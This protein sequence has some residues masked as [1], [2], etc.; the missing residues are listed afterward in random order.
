MARDGTIT[1]V[2]GKVDP[3]NRT[4]GLSGFGGDGGPA[5]EALLCRPN[6]VAPLPDGGFLV[7]D[8][9][10]HAVRRVTAE[11]IITT[12]AGTPSA[13]Q[14][15]A[16]LSPPTPPPPAGDGGAATAA[17]LAEPREV[18]AMPDGGFLIADFGGGLRRVLAEGTITAAAAGKIE[19]VDVAPDGRVV[20]YDGSAGS[21]RL[22][23]AGGFVTNIAGPGKAR[24]RG[25]RPAFIDDDG[26]DARRTRWP[27][28]SDSAELTWDPLGGFLFSGGYVVRQLVE[29]PS[30]RL[31]VGIRASR[32]T[33]RASVVEYRVTGSGIA[34]IELRRTNDPARVV[35]RRRA[36]AQAGLNGVGLPRVRP[37]GY[38]VT[39]RVTG[40][41]GSRDSDR[42]A[43]VLGGRLPIHVAASVA[44]RWECPLC[45]RRDS[46]V[47]ADYVG[48]CRRL[49]RRRVDCAL[50]RSDSA[51]RRVA[52]VVLRPTG[53]TWSRSYPCPPRPRPRHVG[54]LR[55]APLG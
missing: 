44:E 49:N 38:D 31:G 30:D 10:N 5:T 53:F 43:L 8:T 25:T 16:T 55:P 41:N 1:T 2:A 51:C 45:D 52:S 40:D 37:D 9:G 50:A 27:A 48:R 14:P 15:C 7:A 54:R 35:A 24:R 26:R 34:A 29:T 47:D 19:A 20:F 21:I 6:D 17:V 22:A 39:V 3:L 4:H 33:A 46:E 11:G 12:V 32:A 18:A 23:T 13:S 42:L 36:V 28:E